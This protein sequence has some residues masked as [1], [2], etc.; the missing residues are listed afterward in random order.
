MSV[1]V[2]IISTR[3][4]MQFGS[5]FSADNVRG[6]IGKV[7][8][9]LGDRVSLLRGRP[10]DAGCGGWL[11]LWLVQSSPYRYPPSWPS[12]SRGWGSV[13][14]DAI[15]RFLLP[16]LFFFFFFEGLVSTVATNDRVQWPKGT[17]LSSAAT[18]PTSWN[19][20][21]PPPRHTLLP[22]VSRLFPTT[23]L[24]LPRGYFRPPRLAQHTPLHTNTHTLT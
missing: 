3:N 18:L 14:K 24:H 16:A 8:S 22:S 23:R 5:T 17:N 21:S 2:N 12:L 11:G 13:M 4:R 19:K 1:L 15:T 6:L 9:S 7:I 10:A 20:K